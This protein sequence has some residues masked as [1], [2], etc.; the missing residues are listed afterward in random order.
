MNS[1]KILI[2]GIQGALAKITA[3]LLTKHYPDIQIHGVDSRPIDQSNLRKQITAQQ[4]KY[5]RT[6]FEKL[7]R[8]HQFDSVFASWSTRTLSGLRK[9]TQANRY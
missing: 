9:Y 7:F 4:I 1:K 6:N 5:N 8:E 3:E 2:I